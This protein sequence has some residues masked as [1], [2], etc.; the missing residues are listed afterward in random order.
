MTN[1]HNHIHT[2][3]TYIRMEWKSE[4]NRNRTRDWS[5]KQSHLTIWKNHQFLTSKHLCIWAQPLILNL[6][7]IS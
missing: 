3:H 7:L 5:Y 1:L 6:C 2:H 4:W